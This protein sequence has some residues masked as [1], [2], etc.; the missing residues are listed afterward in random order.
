MHWRKKKS[1]KKRTREGSKE[2]K[3]NKEQRI[4]E[5]MKRA[6]TIKGEKTKKGFFL[7][8]R[9][10]HVAESNKR[11]LKIIRMKQGGRGDEKES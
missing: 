9:K 11:R 8:K 3:K 6:M 1:Q 5:S 10:I 2:G 4:K 7:S